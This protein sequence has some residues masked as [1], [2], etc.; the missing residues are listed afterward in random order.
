MSGSSLIDQSIENS[1]STL[2]GL[3]PYEK[4]IILDH[5]M[6]NVYA[7]RMEE[8]NVAIKSGPVLWGHLHWMG[9]MADEMKNPAIY[10]TTLN[11]LAIAHPCSAC[12]SHIPENLKA[13]PVSDYTSYFTH[14]IDLHN[15]VNSQLGNPTYSAS[16]AGIYYGVDC[17]SCVFGAP[18]NAR[19]MPQS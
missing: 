1:V 7:D 15:L 18:T 13:V 19:S 5:I 9:K 8:E 12:R 2:E 10:T 6:D 11:L 14:S 16:E 17:E 3:T 4:D